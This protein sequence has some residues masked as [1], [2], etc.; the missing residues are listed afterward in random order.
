MTEDERARVRIIISGRVQGV[1]FRRATA[2][3]GRILGI[4]GW[5]RNLADGS[6][7]LVGE[8]KRRNLELLLAWTRKGPPHARVEAVQTQW[9]L[10]Q[11]EFLQFEVR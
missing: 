4:T 3:Q 5:V 10:C 7:E 2:E 9:E 11:D 6:V 1:F 8:G